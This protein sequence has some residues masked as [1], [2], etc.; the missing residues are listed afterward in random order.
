[1]RI[2]FGYPAR[3]WRSLHP[4]HNPLA[5][6]H[7]RIE[8]AVLIV[9]FLGILL[10]LPFAAATGST[11]YADQRAVAAQE[12]SSR[13][14]ATA[15]VLADAPVPVPASEGDMVDTDSAGVPARWIGA[16]GNQHTGTI[17]A[18]AGTRAGTQVPM[19]LSDTG[20]PTTPPASPVDAAT[21]AVIAAAFGW[22]LV[23]GILVLG[24][25]ITR[26][27][28]DRRRAAMWDQ[29]W[30]RVSGDWSHY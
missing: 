16:D 6:R 27:L 22:L 5:R 17:A 3:L 13:H 9:V 24:Y 12:Q 10:T 1:V 21:T 4:G 8:A 11:T 15:T 20:M 2:R 29:D 28:L 18:P 7:D 23:I 26:W 30:A 19:W 14:L 25:W